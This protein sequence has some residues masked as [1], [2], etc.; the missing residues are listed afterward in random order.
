MICFGFEMGWR[1]MLVLVLF[2]GLGWYRGCA[3][4]RSSS[5]TE[6]RF[7]PRRLWTLSEAN[8]GIK[9]GERSEL[10]LTDSQ[11]QKWRHFLSAVTM[12]VHRKI[13]RLLNP[14]RKAITKLMG[15][16]ADISSN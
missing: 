3:I 7:D 14:N 16:L 10:R 8:Q 12:M 11:S 4:G 13:V 6:R 9:P 1:R 5:N 2:L 15:Y